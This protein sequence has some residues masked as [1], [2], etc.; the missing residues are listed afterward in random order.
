MKAAEFLKTDET[1]KEMKVTSA[2]SFLKAGEVPRKPH[3]VTGY[4]GPEITPEEIGKLRASG[5]TEEQ[6]QAEVAGIERDPWIDPMTVGTAAFGATGV[7]LMRAGAKL[8]PAAGRAALSGVVSG[9]A[10]VPIGTLAEKAGEKHPALAYPVSLG[11]GVLSGMTLE[12]ALEKS[13]TKG[14]SKAAGKLVKAPH[15]VETAFA[16]KEFGERFLKGEVEVP[17]PKPIPTKTKPKDKIGVEKAV[18]SVLE[19]HG[20]VLSQFAHGKEKLVKTDIGVRTVT[21]KRGKNYKLN[22]YT[23]EL[24]GGRQRIILSDDPTNIVDAGAIVRPIK[25]GAVIESLHSGKTGLP[26]LGGTLARIIKKRFGKIIPETE[27]PLSV[28]GR[29]ATEKLAAKSTTLYGGLPIHKLGEQYTKH[30]GEPVWDKLVMKKLPKLLEKVPGGKAV[31]RAFLYDYRGNL[32]NTPGYIKSMEDMKRYQA[33]GREYAVDLGKRLQAVPEDAQ[34]RMG[35]YIRGEIDTLTGKELELANEAKRS[36]YDLGKQSVDLGM[37]SEQTFFKNAGRYMP[38]LYTSKEYQSLLTKFN[39][40]KPNRLDLSRFKKR[41]DIPKAIREQMGEILTPGYPVAKGITQLTHD[42]EMARFFNGVASNPEWALPKKTTEAIPK[43]WKQLPSNKKLGSLSEGYVHP[44]I[45]ADLQETIHVMTNPEKYWRKALG[46]WKF[47]KVIVS[48]KTHTR[49]LMSNSVLAHLGGLPMYEQPIYLTKGAKAMVKKGNY[50]KI[51][52]EEGLLRHTFTNAEL[53]ALFD[54]VEGQLG[55]IKAASI[56]E[57]LGKVGKGWA[58]T[59]AGLGKAAKLYEAEEQWFKMA[60]LIHNIERKGMKPTE[61]AKDAEKWLFNY[62]K[63]TKFQ[64]KYRSKWYGAPFCTFTFKAMPRIAESM[65]KTPWRFALPMSMIYGLERAA[66]RKIGDTPEEIE[67]KKSLRPEWQKGQML[68]TPNFARVPIVDEYGREYYLNL[69]YILP[70]GDIGEGGGFGPIPGGVMPFSQPFVKEPISQIM[71][72]DPFWKEEIVKEKDV[73]G[74]TKAGKLATEAKLRGKHAVQALAP[75]PVM[76]IAKGVSSLRGKPDYKGRLR[77]P[78][79]VA[80]DVFAGVKLYP[81]DYVEQTAREIGKL[82]P[83]KGYLARKIKG[84]IR[85]LAIKKK[86]VKEAGGKVALYDK[87]IKDKIGQLKGLAEEARKV[88]TTYGKI[89]HKKK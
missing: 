31:N 10:D 44:E 55:G 58:K 12:R 71:N 5:M 21:T 34:L 74:K 41:K 46:A 66:Q 20:S 35:E 15:P 84:D 68:G 14:V 27:A 50:W 6:I 43:G 39:L 24:E 42:V 26:N 3:G 62:A 65:V 17:K 81:V 28:A 32:P 51:A 54:Q 56:P 82:D 19:P 4:F 2:L 61:A 59:K 53:R 38:R 13:I 85:T 23:Y 72:Y 49:N 25:D 75:T 33:V 52:K 79:V 48:P 40:T 16:K 22:A 83:N 78:G 76:D 30:I 70:W 11:V 57:A 1:N 63:V 69:T 47:G 9:A 77:P 87:Q 73:A 80:A 37:L 29:K 60:K 8:A 36:L 18:E 88:G 89:K 7:G 64:E 45:F 86:A 67:A